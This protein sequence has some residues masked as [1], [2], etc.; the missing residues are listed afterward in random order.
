M[1]IDEFI[2]DSVNLLL[3]RQSQTT[4]YFSL[5]VIHVILDVLTQFDIDL[6]IKNDVYKLK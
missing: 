3:I 6:D 1:F 5:E 4:I 2:N